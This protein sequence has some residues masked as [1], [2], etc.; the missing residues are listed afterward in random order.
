MP[1]LPEQNIMMPGT[2]EMEHPSYYPLKNQ[3]T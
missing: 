2:I 3:Y 1:L